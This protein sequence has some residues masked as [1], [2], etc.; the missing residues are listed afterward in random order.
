MSQG[1]LCVPWIW[2]GT[3]LLSGAALLSPKTEPHRA[4]PRRARSRFRAVQQ[5][6]WTKHPD[7]P[8]SDPKKNL[9]P[10]RHR[11]RW[12]G[13]RLRPLLLHLLTRC[14]AA[15]SNRFI[16]S[17]ALPP[18]LCDVLARAGAPSSLAMSALRS[19]VVERRVRGLHVA[20]DHSRLRERVEASEPHDV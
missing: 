16:S 20:P 10:A 12:W 3:L 5:N 4:G 13:R 11:G 2:M 18:K 8:H 15:A 1:A 9:F 6:S 19:H 14:M 17:L 7:G